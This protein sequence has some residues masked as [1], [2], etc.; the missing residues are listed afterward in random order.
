[1]WTEA[2]AMAHWFC[3]TA[4]LSRA[5]T[6]TSGARLQPVGP[7]GPPRAWEKADPRITVPGFA[8]ALSTLSDPEVT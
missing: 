5:L 7:W 1:M 6:Q 2:A 4:L 3:G 8:P